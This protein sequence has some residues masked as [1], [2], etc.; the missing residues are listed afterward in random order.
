M[1]WMHDTLR[2]FSLDPAYRK[3]HQNDLTFAMLYEY[4]ERFVMP[5]SHDEVVH[6]KGSLLRKMAGD[7]WQKFGNL[8]LLLAYQYTRPGKSLLFM[9]TELAPDREWNHEQS[10]DWHLADDPLRAGLQTLLV[11]LGALYRERSC[12]WRRDADSAGFRWIDCSDAES[13]I[14]SYVRRD[15]ERHLVVV[16]NMTPVPRDGYRIGMPS[17]GRYD[18]VLSTDDE[19]FAGSGYLAEASVATEPIPFHGFDQSVGLRLP[20]LAMLILEPSGRK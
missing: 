11:E 12:L 19:R 5:I 18:L 4:S 7:R 15:G 14:F 8:R 13:S 6:G 2:Y 1:G 17:A 3:Y 9:G 20:P 16:A 10:L